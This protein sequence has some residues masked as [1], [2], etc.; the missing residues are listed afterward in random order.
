MG[1]N[2]EKVQDN[3][4]KCS[5][6]GFDEKHP[7]FCIICGRELVKYKDYPMNK[8]AAVLEDLKKRPK[9]NSS[10]I[11][12]SNGEVS[13]EY[14]AILYFADDRNENTKFDPGEI[15]YITTK[16]ALFI[17]S[18][19]PDGNAVPGNGRLEGGG[20]PDVGAAA[21]QSGVAEMTAESILENCSLED[22]ANLYIISV[23]HCADTSDFQDG[24]IRSISIKMAL[25]N[26]KDWDRKLPVKEP[27]HGDY[28]MDQD[29][30][31]YV[32][33]SGGWISTKKPA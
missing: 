4:C 28:G 11:R 26:F 17:V 30:N 31:L 7:Q 20:L 32:Y 14:K 29:R 5:S 22:A 21:G 24:E 10:K 25:T 1:S 16:N 23:Q 15:T 27:R 33:T 3:F 13:C 18:K 12:I 9:A 19:I 2:D 8:L 6:P